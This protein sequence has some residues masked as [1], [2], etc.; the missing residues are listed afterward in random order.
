M[1][2][3]LWK[4]EPDERDG[5]ITNVSFFACLLLKIRGLSLEKDRSRVLSFLLFLEES[6]YLM[7]MT[8]GL[9]SRHCPF[10]NLHNFHNRFVLF[11]F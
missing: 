3:L 2:N 8:V 9:R 7:S 10:V 11:L 4:P 5:D 1:E 6:M